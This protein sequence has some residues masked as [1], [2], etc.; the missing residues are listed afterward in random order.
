[1]VVF[2][3][4]CEIVYLELEVG[5]RRKGVRIVVI[6]DFRIEGHFIIFHKA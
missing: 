6:R 1:M 2:V 5:L 4:C 3:N